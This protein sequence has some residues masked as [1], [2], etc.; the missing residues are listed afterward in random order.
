MTNYRNDVLTAH[1][2]DREQS[3][4]LGH[5]LSM[6]KQGDNCPKAHKAFIN[7]VSKNNQLMAE[8]AKTVR[9][10]K[11]GFYVVF[12]T[13]QAIHKFINKAVTSPQK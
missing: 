3:Y 13:R 5:N 11:K 4:K 2:L 10:T 8:F 1:R 9:T 12:Y 7:K 6:I